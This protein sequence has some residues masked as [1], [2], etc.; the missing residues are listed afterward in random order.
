LVLHPV[1]I[2]QP[3]FALVQRSIGTGAL[4]QAGGLSARMSSI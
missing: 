2:A 3:L 4:D 1:G